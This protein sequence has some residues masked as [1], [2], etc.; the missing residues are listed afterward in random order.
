MTYFITYSELYPL[1]FI[2]ERKLFSCERLIVVDRCHKFQSKLN[3][4]SEIG[5]VT[6]VNN[7][8]EYIIKVPLSCFNIN[9][10][11]ELIN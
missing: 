6:Y 4:Y 1:R 10:A 11:V 7:E 5:Y 2:F 3:S 8:N 9:L